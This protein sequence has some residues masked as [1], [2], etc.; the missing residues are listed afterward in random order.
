MFC[1][2]CGT[3]VM[4]GSAHC[5]S[6]GTRVDGVGTAAAIV[7]HAARNAYAAMDEQLKRSLMFGAGSLFAALVSILIVGSAA[8][9]AF[10]TVPAAMALGIVAMNAGRSLDNRAGAYL[11][12][13]GLISGAVQL[14]AGAI[15]YMV[16]A[17]AQSAMA[18]A[19]G[20]AAGMAGRSM[21]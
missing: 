8:I 6:C 10:I 4:E 12:T 5:T 1:T 17:A 2:N 7:G 9:L 3:Q 11:G 13:I 16:R 21:F 15:L 14:H 20:S 18:S 19:L